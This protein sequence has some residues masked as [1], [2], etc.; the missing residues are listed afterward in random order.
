[1]RFGVYCVAKPGMIENAVSRCREGRSLTVQP[2]L[3]GVSPVM[4]RR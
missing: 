4:Q 1:M 2:L 3:C